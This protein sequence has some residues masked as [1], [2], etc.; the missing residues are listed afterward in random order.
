M[1]TADRHTDDTTFDERRDG[2]DVPAQRDDRDYTDRDGTDSGYDTTPGQDEQ[3]LQPAGAHADGVYADNPT[4]TAHTPDQTVDHTADADTT[5]GDP[6]VDADH[7][8]TQQNSVLDAQDTDA[9]TTTEGPAGDGTPAV[10]PTTT[11]T[12]PATPASTGT[13]TGSGELERLVP[14]ERVS[15]YTSRWDAVKGEFVDEPRTAVAKADALVGELLDELDQLFRRQRSD[16][17]TGLDAD[18]TSTE[19]LRLAMRRY[20]SFFDRLLAL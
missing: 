19:D 13:G 1:T 17:E 20:R 10:A 2:Y 16:L 7:D 14:T 5:H 9:R 6:R 4:D 3:H 8:H 15:E 12:T 18:E 11:D